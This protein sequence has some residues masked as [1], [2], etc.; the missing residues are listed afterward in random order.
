MK[1]KWAI[2]LPPQTHPKGL[3]QSPGIELIAKGVGFK[4]NTT[5]FAIIQ[6]RELSIQSFWV[7]LRWKRYICVLSC[8]LASTLCWGREIPYLEDYYQRFGE[9]KKQYLIQDP[10][11]RTSLETFDE[12]VGDFKSFFSE[13][14]YL[15]VKP[16]GLVTGNLERILRVLSEDGFEVINFTLFEFTPNSVK[17]CWYEESRLF[18]P[19]W[20][21]LFEMVLTGK[22]SV[23]FLLRDTKKGGDF[24][25]ACE[26]L[27]HLKGSAIA[28]KR[29][30][31][32]IRARIEAGSGL[33]GYIHAADS[34]LSM[35]REWGIL[36]SEKQCRQLLRE[37][38]T[39]DR[40]RLVQDLQD[41]K[42]RINSSVP[43]HDLSIS[44]AKEH[45]RLHASQL[46]DSLKQRVLQFIEDDSSSWLDFVRWLDD[47]EIDLP[48]WDLIALCAERRSW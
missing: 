21:K 22:T 12:L 45:L 14:A 41:L 5:P 24:P 18:P 1:Q 40:R 33:F 30:P 28:S 38:T 44:T 47:N 48:Q 4:F 27:S 34:P 39:Y 37:R 11:Y 42:N 29:E 46:E 13:Y 16:D 10:F 3:I 25:S 6:S 15:V 36:I 9:Q 8:A 7:R 43:F 19:K 2:P 26:R 17:Q 32:H 31:W 23:L 35:I 20:C